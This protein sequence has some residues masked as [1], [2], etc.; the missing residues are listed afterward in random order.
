[1]RVLAESM[2]LNNNNLLGSVPP[3]I[4][5]LHSIEYMS[6][7]DNTLSGQIPTQINMLRHLGKS[8]KRN[9]P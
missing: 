9:S 3:E 2:N 6:M 8:N 5:T 4:G 7:R 1:M